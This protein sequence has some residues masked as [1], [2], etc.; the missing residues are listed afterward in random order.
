M[1]AILCL[2][3]LIIAYSAACAGNSKSPNIILILADDLG[4]N[5]L[6]CYGSDY[7]ETPNLDRMA[8]EGMR[9]TQ[10]YTAAPVCSPVRASI[11]T[12]KHPA[13]LHLTNFIPGNGTADTAH[14]EVPDW[15]KYLP[16]NET[17]IAEALKTQGYATAHF[18]KWHLSKEKTPPG[19]LSHNPDEQGYDESF[20]TYK[21]GDG[22]GK[23]W[24]DAENDP[25]NVYVIT[26]MGLDF[27]ERHQSVPFFLMLSHN[28]I[29]TPL[30]D[31][32]T[33]IKK[34]SQKPGHEL[35]ENNP[36][37]AAMMETLDA[38]VGRVLNRVQD[39]GLA[40]N[41]L[42][43]FYSDNGGLARVNKQT[44]LRSGKA[45]LY[46]GGIR[47]PL[48]AHWPGKV[49]AGGE[50]DELITSNDLFPT[51]S[52][53]SGADSKDIDGLSFLPVLKGKKDL[54]RD[55]LYWHF[56][57]FH[58]SGEGP[59]GA[60]RQGNYKLIEWYDPKFSNKEKRLELYDLF[61]DPG[62]ANDLSD[63]MPEQTKQL[64]EKLDLWRTRLNAQPLQ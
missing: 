44:P 62:E 47:V 14:F 61:Q 52:E 23:P 32:A 58:P 4:I 36:I 28:S 48:I 53:I 1:K 41:T 43:V 9:F 15:R 16:L 25:H 8:A 13:G 26:R 11:Q 33:L 49:A 31:K 19:S 5:Q 27:I 2:I 45:S 6:G 64:A 34:Y 60:I 21:P 63:Q 56:P 18:G 3:I 12:G 54:D 20:V 42:V 46:E 59:S 37:I 7:Y 57:H 40:E 39:L 24:Q 38:S 10:A 55:T 17:T 30:K 51:F 35:P 22:M 50:S 29:H